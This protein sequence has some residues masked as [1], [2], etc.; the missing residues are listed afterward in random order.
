MRMSAIALCRFEK[1]V[2]A[3]DVGYAKLTVASSFYIQ[4]EALAQTLF[5]VF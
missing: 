2:P 5:L 1:F 4:R 3:G